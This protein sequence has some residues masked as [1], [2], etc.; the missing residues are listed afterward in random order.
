MTHLSLIP[1]LKQIGPIVDDFNTADN[2][3]AGIRTT[4]QCVSAHIEVHSE[5]FRTVA[6]FEVDDIW[7]QK[8]SRNQS[9]AYMHPEEIAFKKV[10]PALQENLRE[11]RDWL[12]E[13]DCDPSFSDPIDEALNMVEP[14]MEKFQK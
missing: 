10:G 14:H 8:L 2:S 5:G 7:S 4:E 13:G 6:L 3:L 12:A 1:V 9:I 11:V